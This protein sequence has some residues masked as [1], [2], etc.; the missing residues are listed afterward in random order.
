MTGTHNASAPLTAGEVN[1]LR[2]VASGLANF[3]SSDHQLLLTAM[4]FVAT[5]GSG[6][7]VLTQEG[8]E[9][10]AEE[11]AT[12]PPT[13]ALGARNGDNRPWPALGSRQL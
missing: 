11:T 5:T 2:R 1:A 3:L 4:G 10:L 8:K 6:H 7:L 9:R 12:Q 13:A